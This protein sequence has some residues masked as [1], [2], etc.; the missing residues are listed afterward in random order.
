MYKVSIIISN[1]NYGAFLKASI[2]SALSQTYRP[3]EVIVV[4]D[5]STDHSE[6]ILEAYRDKAQVFRLPHQG[7]TASRNF[8]FSKTS[9]DII[10]F[11]D[12]DDFLQPDTVARIVEVWKPEFTKVQ[13]HLRVVNQDGVD[14]GLLMPRCRLDSGI[15]YPL[16]LR[17]GRYITSPG[18]GN[19]YA[20][21]FLEKIVPVPV[22]EWPQS[23]DS[24]AATCAGFLGE[25]GAVQEP[26]GSYRVHD[27]NMTRTVNDGALESKQIERLLERQLRLRRLIQRIAGE[28][29]LQVNPGIVTSHWL[30]L[31]LELAKRAQQPD[32]SFRELVDIVRKMIASAV[33][34]SEL[35]FPRRI[36]LIA[37]AL[38]SALLPKGLSQQVMRMGFDLAPDSR[39]TRVMRRL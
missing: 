32:T 25:V 39:F 37:W 4:D 11:L 6:E 23:F 8:G 18:S 10:C 7:E 3:S 12:A 5:G 2:E 22:D 34:A 28:R 38:G 24:Y 13:Y 16:L 20:K 27:N 33:S 15:V 26:L 19:F 9:G 29:G 21:S 17:T 30:Y 36:Q 14:Q 1:F 35:S 31:K